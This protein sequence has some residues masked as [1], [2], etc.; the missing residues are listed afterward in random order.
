MKPRVK[1]AVTD[2]GDPLTHQRHPLFRLLDTA[3]ELEI[4]DDPD[5]LIFSLGGEDHYRYKCTK[6]YYTAENRRP[7]FGL[8]DY[9]FSFEHLNRPDHYRLP[10]YAFFSPH[11]L[12]KRDYDPQRI[13][14]DKTGFCS[15]VVSNPGCAVRNGFFE[16]LSKYKR[17]DSGGAFANN[18]GRRVKNKLDFVRRYKFNIAFENYSNR[19]YTTEKIA[20]AMRADSLP[21]YWGNPAVGLEFNTNSFLNYHDFSC[22]D[23]LI[24]RIVELDRNDDAYL[25]MLE[26]PWLHGNE[27]AASLRPE[28]ILRKFGEIFAAPLKRPRARSVLYPAYSFYERGKRR[29]NDQVRSCKMALSPKKAA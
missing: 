8:C 17:V 23:E 18:I 10:Y 22:E 13:L 7:H 15:F 4:S 29:F 24:D 11:E 20:D 25:E 12:V 3:F 14:A 16:K 6:I 27:L 1:I 21:I 26:K 19:G 28:S 9:A 2:F 5:F